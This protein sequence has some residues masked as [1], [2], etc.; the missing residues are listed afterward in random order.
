[1]IYHNPE[2]RTSCNTLEMMRQSGDEPHVIEYLKTPPSRAKLIDLLVAMGITPRELL[3][4][5]ETPPEEP[6]PGEASLSDEQLIDAMLAQPALIDRPIVVTE[7]GVRLCTP[8]EKVL[9][10]LAY[11]PSEFTREDGEVVRLDELC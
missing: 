9:D 8:S 1:M 5:R 10:L 11:P 6:V 3:R 2:C 7:L 4:P